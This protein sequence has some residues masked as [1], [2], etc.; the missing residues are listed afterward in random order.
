MR[1]RSLLLVVLVTIVSYGCQSNYQPTSITVASYSSRNANSG[2]SINRNGWGQ[3]YSVIA[4]VVQYR[5]FD[6]FDMQEC[7]IHQLKDMKETLPDYDYTGIGRDDGKE[8]DGH[9]AIFYRTDKSDMIEKGGLWLSETPGMP[10]KGWGTVLPR[11][12]SW[13]HLK[14]KDIGFEFLFFNLYMDHIGKKAC[15]E[16]VFPVQSRIKELGKGREL[17]VILMGDFNVDQTH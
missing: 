13:G 12:C 1:L 5:D 9:S 15:V 8:E 17:P 7:F 3:R 14:Y 16:S 10:N 11:T 4:Q 2:D 6:A